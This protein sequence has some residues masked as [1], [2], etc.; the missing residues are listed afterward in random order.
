MSR[1]I[2]FILSTILLTTT[3]SFLFSATTNAVSGAN[4]RAGY[5]IDDSLMY[6]P[7][8]M[9]TGSI[10]SFLASKVPVCDTNGTQPYAG[11]TRAAYGA[12]RGYPAPYT[13]LKDYTENVG[14]RGADAYCSGIGG[15]WKSSTSIIYEVAHA[16]NIS[17]KVLLVMLEK[18]QGLISDD[19][20][21]SLQYRGA[22]GYGCPDT[23]ACDSQYYGFFNQVYNAA[24]QY[25]VYAANQSSYRYKP[26][27][28]N[29]I[30]WNPNINCGGSNVYT[31]NRATA[32]LYNYTPYQPNA[33]ALNNLYGSGDGC[34]AYGNRNFWRLYNDW[35]GST[36]GNPYAWEI[37]GGYEIYDET[38]TVRIDPGY[39]EPG[40]K[41]IVRATAKNIG[42]AT[43]TNGGAHPVLLGTSSGGN[44]RF[45]A[46]GWVACNRPA[47]LQEASVA[48]GASGHFEFPFYAPYG[49]G[50]YRESFRPVAEMRAWF[51]EDANAG[52]GVRVV[53]PGSF[54]WNTQGYT[55]QNLSKTA[56]IDPG[57]L[58]PNQRYVA[59]ITGVNTGSATWR[60]NSTIPVHLGLGNM[61]Q[62]CT[63][64]WP[65]CNRPAK[66]TETS[67]APGQTGSFEFTFQAPSKPGY[68]SEYFTPVAEMFSW[69]N[70]DPES[71]FGVRVLSPGT[72]TWSTQ[73]YRIMN[74]GKTQDVDPGYLQ[75]NTRYTAILK[76][77]NTG[78]ATW[79]NQYPVVLA[80]TSGTSS[81]CVNTWHAPCN[82]IVRV[83]ES[84]VAP[85]QVGTFEF[86]FQTPGG[87]TGRF[88]YRQQFKPVVEMYTWFNDTPYDEFGVWIQ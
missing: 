29:F 3:I 76:A 20:P 40:R 63:S 23:A 86:T 85:G 78:T 43:W 31:E 80:A 55:I 12:S 30:Q 45:C 70:N 83:T 19:W 1:S 13:C 54:S 4:W 41:Y 65:S 60:N 56:Y 2:K 32:G 14:A 44:S 34:S 28:T 33:P 66:L 84:S 77:T 10:G 64:G 21:W 37:N 48:P 8:D 42:T 46:N 88:P 26:Y 68:Y 82:R 36:T 81:L 71:G 17:A 15:G 18:E 9:S 25:K 7:S 67:V 11:T 35:F 52:F 73:G 22:M 16:C 74:E 69:F 47:L 57:A 5:I 75:R 72:F 87:G 38:G 79:N 59:R 58:E 61:S 49:A 51:N 50:E 53:S 27:Q 39:L 6:T 24:R 62:F